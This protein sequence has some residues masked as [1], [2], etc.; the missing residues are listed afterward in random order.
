[1][2]VYTRKWKKF[3]QIFDGIITGVSTV[4]NVD[5]RNVRSKMNRCRWINGQIYE[6]K[7]CNSLC[8]IDICFKETCNCKTETTLEEFCF[9]FI[10]DNSNMSDANLIWLVNMIKKEWTTY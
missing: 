2:S 7:F 4:R 1:M 10:L 3:H 5:I 6:N 8:D 9:E